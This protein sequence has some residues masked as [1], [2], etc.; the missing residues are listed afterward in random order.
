[1]TEENVDAQ[2]YIT[3]FMN[4]VRS[5][6]EADPESHLTEDHAKAAKEM[7]DA[8]AKDHR[9]GHVTE[10]LARVIASACSNE[11]RP[12]AVDVVRTF[13]VLSVTLR[14]EIAELEEAIKQLHPDD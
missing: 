13:T 6:H 5:C 2:Q 1:M 3:R 12:M 9:I 4:M 11:D 10:A 8:M 7:A 14:A